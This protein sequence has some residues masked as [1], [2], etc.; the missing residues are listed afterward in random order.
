MPYAQV[1]DA[2]GIFAALFETG[3]GA[4]GLEGSYEMTWLIHRDEPSKRLTARS[5]VFG[6]SD[7]RQATG[8]KS[9]ILG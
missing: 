5:F 2:A 9:S 7:L 4:S 1:D 3:F 8:A 6:I